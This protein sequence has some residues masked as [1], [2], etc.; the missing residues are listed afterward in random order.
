MDT[1]NQMENKNHMNIIENTHSKEVLEAIVKDIASEVSLEEDDL[2]GGNRFFEMINCYFL[3]KVQ[4]D[5]TIKNVA[6]MEERGYGKETSR[7]AYLDFDD[8]AGFYGEQDDR[9]NKLLKLIGKYTDDKL[10]EC[11]VYLDYFDDPYEGTPISICKLVDKLLQIKDTD[12][13]L[14]LN[15]QVCDFTIYSCGKHVGTTY[16]AIS[17]EYTGLEKAAIVADVLDLT[18]IILTEGTNNK[19]YDKAFANNLVDPSKSYDSYNLTDSDI[20]GDL[21]EEWP[22]FPINIS[23][24]WNACGLAFATASEDGRAVAL[25][26]AGQLTVRQCLEERAFMCQNGCIEGV[27]ML[28]NKMY[29]DTWVNPYLLILSRG[30]TKVRFYDASS[31]SETNRIGGKRINTLSD[32]R[33]DQIVEE[34]SSGINTA[35]VDIDELKSNDYNLNPVRYLNINAS[36]NKTIRLGDALREVK[37]GMTLS[38]AQ[39]DDLISEEPSEKKCIIPSSINGG[40]ISSGLYYHGTIKKPG[41][42]EVYWNQVLVSKTGNPFRAALAFDLY[43][44]IGNLYILD[45]NSEVLN[46]AY[47]RCFLNSNMGQRELAKYATGSATPVI[48]I[49]DLQKIEVPVFEESKQEELNQRCE[50]IVADLERCYRQIRN[51]NDE[52]NGLFE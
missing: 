49:S 40:I 11:L 16:T 38:A 45:I 51:N 25:M 4:T 28:P 35:D 3:W 15:A 21:E 43:L 39:M 31:E 19:K 12:S 33:I 24:A 17:G 46:P 2:L 30:N 5:R 7:F 47:V 34:Y 42:N 44:V 6:E 26:N 50:E 27:I 14:E 22:E 9:W 13:V 23:N 20:A 18:D 48:N 32:E 41:K 8:L 36:S 29:E 1:D 52:V 10:A 37:R